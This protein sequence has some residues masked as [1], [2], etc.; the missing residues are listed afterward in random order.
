MRVAASVVF[1]IAPSRARRS[2]R[3]NAESAVTNLDPRQR[4]PACSGRVLASPLQAVL[5]E[6]GL[7]PQPRDAAERTFGRLRQPQ[8]LTAG[9]QRV[10][11][12][13]VQRAQPG[14]PRG[15]VRALDAYVLAFDPA[16]I[17]DEPLQAGAV[18]GDGSTA[19]RGTVR[20][21]PQPFE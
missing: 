7:G 10:V 18:L 3:R 16:Q 15:Q 21:P 11:I 4:A 5:G 17:L 6:L 20:P 19:R 9:A 1:S 12:R 2:A 14:R 13:Q 8:R